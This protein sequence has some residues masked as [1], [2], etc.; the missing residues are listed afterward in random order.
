MPTAFVCD[1]ERDCS[2]GDDEQSCKKTR[3]ESVETEVSAKSKMLRQ[4]RE[5]KSENNTTSK[6][7]QG[8]CPL[9]MSS[10]G[11]G[12][13]CHNN[14][15]VCDGEIDCADARDEAYCKQE[16]SGS[17]EQGRRLQ[18][19][20]RYGCYSWEYDCGLYDY[21]IPYSFVCDLV[22]DCLNGSDE[23]GCVYYYY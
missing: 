17:E 15:H 6:T 1:G 21:C 11:E 16:R 4:Q 3:E 13:A 8:H 18:A 20:A 9:G 12:A 5:E 19:D 10:C 7:S 14:T 23:Y 2:H 22:Y